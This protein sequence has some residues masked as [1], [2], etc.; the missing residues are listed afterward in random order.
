MIIKTEADVSRSNAER[1]AEKYSKV[2]KKSLTV[3]VHKKDND[4]YPNGATTAEV[5]MW[6]EFGTVTLPPRIWL[7]IFNLMEAEK[8]D[9]R[10]QIELAFENDDIDEALKEI[11]AYMADR[12]K[13]RIWSNE[14]KPDSHNKSGMTLL[15]T[16]R[17]VNSINY[18]V[19]DVQ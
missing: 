16:G 6:Q 9:L 1:L 18:E 7:R 5:G 2:G 10:V 17:L 4:T 14:V 11:G 19:K 13:D 3:G 15:D 12:I 8:Q